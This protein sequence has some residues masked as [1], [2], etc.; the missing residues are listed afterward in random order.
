MALVSPTVN[1]VTV[2]PLAYTCWS[3]CE[4]EARASIDVM[5]KTQDL[6][7]RAGR[8]ALPLTLPLLVVWGWG[9]GLLRDGLFVL[10][11]E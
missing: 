4:Q 2:V 8:A 6:T 11:P 9:G 1:M 7:L 3:G 5:M 10:V